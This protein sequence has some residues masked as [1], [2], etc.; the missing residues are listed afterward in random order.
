MLATARDRYWTLGASVCALIVA[1][2]MLTILILAI[3][4]TGELWR[5]LL[6]TVLPRYL[7]NTVALMILA[8]SGVLLIGTATAWLVTMFRFPGS[9]LFEWALL[10]PL[11]IPA[12]VIAFVYVDYLEFAGPIQTALR[13]IF[14]WA[15]PQDYWFPDIQSL[16][17]AAAMMTLVLYPY[18]Y[19]LARNAFLD[20]SVAALEVSRTLG[21]GPWRNF[22]LI[23]LPLARP[24]LAI[25]VALALMEVIGDFG[26]V[27]Q[28]AVETFTTGIY[29]IWQGMNDVAG[30]AQLAGFLLL[31]V[32][33]LIWLERRSRRGRRYHPAGRHFR[34]LPKPV[35]R[36]LPAL[37]AI[38]VCGLPIGL[39]FLVPAATLATWALENYADT[40][41]S[42][43]FTDTGNTLVLATTAAVLTGGLAV[44]LSYAL[45]LGQG[46]LLR[47]SA[48]LA[49]T[50]YAIPGSVIAVGVLIPIGLLDNG[51]D[52]LAQTLFQ[53]STGLIFSG[54]MAILI[55]AYAARFMALSMGA[56]GASLGR[57][58][59][60][61][62]AA[63]QTLGHSGGSIL[64]RVHM[65]M[66]R[67]G[68]LTAVLIVFVEVCKELPA[69]L[70]LRPLDFAT[71]STRIYD[72]AS[73]S[74]Y[75]EAALWAL[76]LIVVGML[77]VVLLSK[78][79]RASRPGH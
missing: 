56:V 78:S 29:E 73:D 76:S 63:A 7:L 40:D 8:G 57:V 32:L 45:R 65:P 71:L 48:R 4:P 74:F 15:R 42:Q 51:I 3:S 35:L 1:I 49:G 52:W 10:L 54:T 47:I 19:L 61:I 33:A 14:G 18:V 34:D 60:N 9:R 66:I 24:A 12:Y 67:G 44:F 21:H 70:L 16:P 72:F 13:S 68:I 20:Q 75:E 69:T 23:G 59:R 11:S 77:P 64:W 41:L 31:I 79:I 17:G 39:G 53:Y 62:D 2:P 28:F 6:A 50:G 38:A 27:Q 55:F 30:A 37:V 43:F 26:T 58:T 46:R 5:H 22:F 36:G 25:G